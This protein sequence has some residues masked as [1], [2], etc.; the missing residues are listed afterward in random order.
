MD[1]HTILIGAAFVLIASF[2]G[3]VIRHRNTR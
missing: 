3:I 1:F 2:V